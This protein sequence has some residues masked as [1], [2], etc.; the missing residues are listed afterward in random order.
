[1]GDQEVEENIDKKSSTDRFCELIVAEREK[2]GF[3]LN[4]A[5]SATRITIAFMEAIERGELQALPGYVFGRGFLRSLCRVYDSD[6]S[7]ALLELY[8]AACVECGIE[9]V[10]MGQPVKEDPTTSGIISKKQRRYTLTSIWRGLR[11]GNYFRATP[12]YLAQGALVLI[13]LVVYLLADPF[14]S[15]TEDNNVN[16]FDKDKKEVLSI[17]KAIDEEAEPVVSAEEE[18]QREDAMSSLPSKQQV[19]MT[20]PKKV[21]LKYKIDGKKWV[22]QD[23]E[24]DN[25]IWEFQDKAEF[26]IKSPEGIVVSYNEQP[27]G[28]L[29]NTVGHNRITFSKPVGQVKVTKF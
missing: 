1:M 28:P 21:N 12:L 18:V 8:K 24:P 17:S 9:D 2:A 3:S 26:Y 15:S 27:I 6:Q 29:Q 14:T 10:G 19:S 4:S 23:L 11:P 22:Q 7:E 20:M 13:V 25:Y 16:L 5:A